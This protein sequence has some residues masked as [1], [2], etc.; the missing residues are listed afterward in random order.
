MDHRNVAIRVI[1]P[2]EGVNEGID[3]VLNIRETYLTLDGVLTIFV[4]PPLLKRPIIGDPKCGN[5]AKSA[6][7]S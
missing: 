7:A 3:E 1:C 6:S 4:T 2:G 5:T